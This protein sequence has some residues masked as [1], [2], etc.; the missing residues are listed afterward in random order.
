MEEDRWLNN[1]EDIGNHLISF[2]KQLFALSS[3]PLGPN[4]ASLISPVVTDEDNHVIPKIKATQA[5][6]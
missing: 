2:F 3:P 1:C 6:G 5:G 4:I